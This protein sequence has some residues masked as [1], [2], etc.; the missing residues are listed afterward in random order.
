MWLVVSVRA[1]ILHNIIYKIFSFSLKTGHFLDQLKLSSF[2]WETFSKLS[3]W[4]TGS[5]RQLHLAHASKSSFITWD[6]EEK[7]FYL[8]C[9]MPG[10]LLHKRSSC[11]EY[12]LLLRILQQKQPTLQWSNNVWQPQPWSEYVSWPRWREW[13]D[14]DSRRTGQACQGSARCSIPENISIFQNVVKVL[15]AIIFLCGG[16][17]L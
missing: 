9:L 1:Q 16:V 17:L 11:C 3:H 12:H 7:Y 8:W 13:M 15:L 4:K 6:V 2:L 14:T 5:L 10:H